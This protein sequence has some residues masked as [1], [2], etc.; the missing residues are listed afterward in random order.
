[1]SKN[2]FLCSERDSNPYIHYLLSL[3]SVFQK[4]SIIVFGN[5]SNH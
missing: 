4:S 3:N 2:N 5:Y 1:M